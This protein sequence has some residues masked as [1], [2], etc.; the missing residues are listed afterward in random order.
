MLTRCSFVSL[1]RWFRTTVEHTIAQ[2]KKFSILSSK[3]RGRLQRDNGKLEAVLD[4]C[5]GAVILQMR[6]RPGRSHNAAIAEDLEY[7]AGEVIPEP[8]FP[9]GNVERDIEPDGHGG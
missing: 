6:H 8:R 9:I 5:V 2:I 1:F 4:I 3:Y 7:K